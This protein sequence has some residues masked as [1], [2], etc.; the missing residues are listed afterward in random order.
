MEIVG[1]RKKAGAV[2]LL[3]QKGDVDNGTMLGGADDYKEHRKA[4]IAKSEA[5]VGQNLEST[6]EKMKRY[7][8]RVTIFDDS[9]LN[10]K[11]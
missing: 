5:R 4:E 11:H 7:D 2:V 9:D 6:K 1:S 10:R 8:S 3:N